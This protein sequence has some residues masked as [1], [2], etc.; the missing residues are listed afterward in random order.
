MMR[1][2][3]AVSLAG[4]LCASATTAETLVSWNGVE[5]VTNDFDSVSRV[6]EVAG[7]APGTV[8]DVSDSKLQAVCDRVRKAFST[9]KVGCTNVTGSRVTPEGPPTAWY[10][11]ELNIAD[12]E[13]PVCPWGDESL[14]EDL[15]WLYQSW[16]R[17]LSDTLFAGVPVREH[18]N[19]K[20]YLDYEHT[21]LASFADRL[22]IATEGREREIEAAASS[23]E[24]SLR[25]A[26]FYLMNF[27]GDPQRFVRLAGSHINDPHAGAA[28]AATRFL[29]TF[30]DFIPDTERPGLAAQAC[31]SLR[32]GG[33]TARNKSLMLLNA[34]R[35]SR[36][37]SFDQLAPDCQRQVRDIARTSLSEQIAVPARELVNQ[38]AR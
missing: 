6:R 18:V 4:M 30:A 24:P 32:E 27:A 25:T 10:I 7:L 3:F 26:G 38:P 9:A 36:T 29:V 13:Q 12:R 2:I 22:H 16:L 11:V 21:E 31:R 33:F 19:A 20:K 15:M 17:T 34:W 35:K 23:C 1:W 8:L 14:P 37:L 5:V 28:N